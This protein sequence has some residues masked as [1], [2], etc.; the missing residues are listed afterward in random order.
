[1][2]IRSFTV[3]YFFQMFNICMFSCSISS[4]QVKLVGFLLADF[5]LLGLTDHLAQVLLPQ[6]TTFLVIIRCRQS[7]KLSRASEMAATE[8]PTTNDRQLEI[9]QVEDPSG[10]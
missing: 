8:V 2:L 4:S 9:S 3:N 7:P 1:M 10:I 5:P 6:L